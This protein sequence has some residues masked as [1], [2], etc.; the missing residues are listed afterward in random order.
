MPIGN[1][2]TARPF[3]N[4][5]AR[6]LEGDIAN[7]IDAGAGLAAK[8]RPYLKNFVQN[9]SKERQEQLGSAM[10]MLPE[11]VNLL[12][13]YYTGL[14]GTNLSHSDRYKQDL[15]PKVKE[16]HRKAAFHRFQLD[17]AELHEELGIKDSEKFIKDIQAGQAPIGIDGKPMTIEYAR[18]MRKDANDALAFI[19]SRMKKM[20]EGYIPFDS[21]AGTDTG[22][23][24]TS[25]GTSLGHA[26]FKPNPDGS[27]TTEETYDFLYADAD[28]KKREAGNLYGPFTAEQEYRNPDRPSQMYAR[29]AAEALLGRQREFVGLGGKK[30]STK[31]ITGAAPITNIGRSV[32]SRFEDD[33]FK[34]SLTVRPK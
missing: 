32:V 16:A 6:T 23:P 22:N 5:S 8:A 14:G 15:A 19:R 34:Y 25:S 33:P 30:F 7:V 11:S 29:E 18:A 20:D 31:D 28:R 3:D 9:L 2:F 21:E 24:L 26:Y 27:Y 4:P 1:Y 13:R 17:R 12:G 10:N